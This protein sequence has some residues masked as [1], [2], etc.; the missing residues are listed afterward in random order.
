[1]AEQEEIFGGGHMSLASARALLGLPSKVFKAILT[2]SNTDDPAMVEK[3]NTTGSILTI[4]RDNT[5]EYIIK[6]SSS[7]FDLNTG[8]TFGANMPISG[9]EGPSFTYEILS[10]T[11]LIIKT[12]S[13]FGGAG[14]SLMNNLI[15]TI[16][17]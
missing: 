3:I 5:G 17:I 15:I 8:V 10:G 13:T 14:D 1:M 12:Y 4:Q 7:I 2:Q 9:E 11:Q 16:E 6:A